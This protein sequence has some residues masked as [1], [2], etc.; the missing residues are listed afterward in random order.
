MSRINRLEKELKGIQDVSM[1]MSG[2]MVEAPPYRK[3]LPVEQKV[4]TCIS[5]RSTL[6]SGEMFEPEMQ[7]DPVASHE[8]KIQ[9]NKVQSYHSKAS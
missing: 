8:L 7:V 3:T 1:R 4:Q 6:R 5:L 2:R 9:V